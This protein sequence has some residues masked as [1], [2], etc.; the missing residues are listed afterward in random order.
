MFFTIWYQ[1]IYSIGCNFLCEKEVLVAK[2]DT[3]YENMTPEELKLAFEKEKI[4]VQRIYSS[5]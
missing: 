2:S 3:D 1:I 4:R 5:D